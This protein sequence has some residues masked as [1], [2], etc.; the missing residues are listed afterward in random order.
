MEIGKKRLWDSG[1]HATCVQLA[2]RSEQQSPIQPN[3]QTKKQAFKEEKNPITH[4]PP[5]IHRRELKLNQ[6]NR[7]HLRKNLR[8]QHRRAHPIQA[9]ERYHKFIRLNQLVG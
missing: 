6:L 2:E 3:K 8:H 4:D 9:R 5:R 1:L 7:H